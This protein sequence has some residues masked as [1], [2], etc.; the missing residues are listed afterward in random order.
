MKKVEVKVGPAVVGGTSIISGLSAGDRVVVSYNR[1]PS[2]GEK[3]ELV[4]KESGETK[5]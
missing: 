1:R 4:S 3:V 5:K 2:D